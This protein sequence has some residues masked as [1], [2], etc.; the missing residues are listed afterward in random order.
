VLLPYRRNFLLPTADSLPRSPGLPEINRHNPFLP[1]RSMAAADKDLV[2]RWE[3]THE[4]TRPSPEHRKIVAQHLDEVRSADIQSGFRRRERQVRD[5]QIDE[6]DSDVVDRAAPADSLEIGRGNGMTVGGIN[7]LSLD[8]MPV[9]P[10]PPKPE[11]APPPT[12]MVAERRLARR[13]RPIHPLRKKCVECSDPMPKH[14][15]PDKEFCSKA[16]TEKARRRRVECQEAVRQSNADILIAQNSAALI[17]Q[18]EDYRLTLSTFRFLLATSGP[19]GAVPA[20]WPFSMRSHSY[21]TKTA[22]RLMRNST[23]RLFRRWPVSRDQ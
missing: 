6:V 8:E 13:V 22:R 10:N 2:H 17:E 23:R 1:V 18:D 7:R 12:D 11:P 5:V 15:R 21:A 20:S 4:V 3:L 14:S 19:S 16:C 9:D